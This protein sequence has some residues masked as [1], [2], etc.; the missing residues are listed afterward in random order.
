MG[1]L[2]PALSHTSAHAHAHAT[3][4][5]R[6]AAVAHASTSGP[7]NRCRRQGAHLPPPVGPRHKMP[8]GGQGTGHLR[9]WTETE[10]TYHTWG[11]RSHTPLVH[12]KP[13]QP[14]P[15][16]CKTGP[17]HR[18]QNQDPTP[19]ARGAHAGTPG[20]IQAASRLPGCPTPALEAPQEHWHRRPASFSWPP[21]TPDLA[22]LPVQGLSRPHVR[23][24]SSD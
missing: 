19:L 4:R 1:R 22:A 12:F 8:P 11:Q 15:W 10:H 13:A 16:P 18:P 9:H 21:S 6:V 24:S 5:A 3:G 7:T 20:Q 17:G 23:I 14:I 2:G